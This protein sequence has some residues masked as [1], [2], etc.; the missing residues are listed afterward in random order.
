MLPGVASGEAWSL[1]RA[2]RMGA[3]ADAGMGKS[4]IAGSAWS[5]IFIGPSC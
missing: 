4:A 5:S 3:A 2:M 1:I